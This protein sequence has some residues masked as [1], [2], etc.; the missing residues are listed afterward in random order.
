M[1]DIKVEEETI[2]TKLKFYGEEIDLKL[3]S[4]YDSF[5]NNVCNIFNISPDQFNSISLSYLDEDEDSIIISTKEDYLIFFQQVREK[6]VNSIIAEINEDS[7]IDPIAALGSAI[8]YKDQ[9]EKA[10]KEINNENKNKNF[11]EI[12]NKNQNINKND[13]INLDV[14][15]SNQNIRNNL[16]QNEQV[17]KNDIPIDNLIFEYKCHICF[18]YPI[19]C[20]LYYCPKCPIYFCESCYQK[21]QNHEHNIIKIESKEQLLKIKE[22]ENNEIEKRHQKENNQ[23]YDYY[24]QYYYPQEYDKQNNQNNNIYRVHGPNE[25]YGPYWPH[26]PYGPFPPFF[27]NPGFQNPIN[28]LGN[29]NKSIF[30]KKKSGIRKSKD[31]WNL[32]RYVKMIHQ[33][34]KKYHLEGI[35]NK[36]LFEALKQAKGNIDE[37][38]TLLANK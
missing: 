32:M 27:P 29:E 2:N 36:R 33:A 30:K 20:V 23:N 1:K 17:I 14:S 35:D 37:A 8:D 31:L 19:I 3:S 6:T 25:V 26:W 38:V 7:K 12:N 4:D 9:I 34:R 22:K 24:Y 11:N 28:N 21:N 13:I 5:I 18:I 15:N 16:I 10:N